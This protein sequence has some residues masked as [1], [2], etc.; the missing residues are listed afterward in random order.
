MQ[1]AA[2]A[3]GSVSSRI[4]LYPHLQA[5]PLPKTR[6]GKG[7]LGGLQVRALKDKQSKEISRPLPVELA[8]RV[9]KLTE[10]AANLEA[11]MDPPTFTEEELQL[12]YQDIICE[13]SPGPLKQETSTIEL[14]EQLAND[15][16][17][18]DAAYHRLQEQLVSESDLEDSPFIR[19]L[20][21]NTPSMTQPFPTIDFATHSQPHRTLLAQVEAFLRRVDPS[22][23]TLSIPV[24]VMS[25]EEWQALIRISLHSNDIKGAEECLVLMKRT[26]IP[27]TAEAVTDII[28]YHANNADIAETERI[29]NTYM[30]GPATDRQ[31][32]LHVRA[33][34]RA[35]PPNTIPE[36][37]LAVLH[38]YEAKSNPPAMNTYTSVI[39]TLFSVR[40]SIANAQ[41]WDLYTHMRYVAHPTPDPFLYTVMIRACA[42]PTFSSRVAEPERALDLWT[43]MT[44]DHNMRPTVATYNAVILACAR[45]GTKTYINEGFRL[46]KEMIESHKDANG[47]PT[48]VPDQQT[49]CALLEGAK[50]I[51]DLN[52]TR[53]ILAKI[54]NVMMEN[55]SPDTSINEEVMMH[56]FHTYASYN[57]PFKRELAPLSD[58]AKE[59]HQPAPSF[60]STSPTD[61]KSNTKA[62]AP[63]LESISFA[64]IAPQSRGEVLAE[65]DI[66]FH[67]SISEPARELF[68]T[69]F[70]KAGVERSARSYKEA[71]E[72]CLYAPKRDREDALVFARELFAEYSSYD[73]SGKEVVNARTIEQVHTAFIRLL[74]ITKN[75]REASERVKA[76]VAKYPPAALRQ[77]DPKPAMRSTRTS[78]FAARPLVRMS[79]IVEVPDSHVPP[80]LLFNDLDVL[81]HR[82]V[83]IGDTAGIAYIKYVCKA[84]EWALRVRRDETFRSKPLVAQSASE[85]R[86]EDEQNL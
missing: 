86:E 47:V 39:T 49:F 8:E 65:V 17:L 2:S 35:T 85:P 7:P 50:R 59:D 74:A 14:N 67:R 28:Y 76:F 54:G 6:K 36:S 60:T 83:H 20:R 18:V 48:Y 29:I 82:F 16:V 58:V 19:A 55:R 64:H 15:A 3:S 24:V 26:G 53:W 84:Y 52:R 57:P 30:T 80:M 33:H 62:R 56:A 81:H 79:S 10:V 34:L 61:T 1:E 37:A 73:I 31:Q 46:A 40:D 78:L 23:S 72:R 27:I 11:T 42:S 63:A 13:P 75:E 21:A 25:I 66:L 44:V 51:G 12:L 69:V 43:E 4:T 45:S 32:H 5:K 41:A 68:N 9:E 22:T 77:P 71:L 70:E 38:A